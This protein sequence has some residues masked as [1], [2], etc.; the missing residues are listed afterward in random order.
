[1]VAA[2][3]D[4][5]TLVGW[6]ASVS[7]GVRHAFIIDLIVDPEWQ[8]QGLGTRLLANISQEFEKSGIGIIHADF[9][10]E[11]ASF[12]ESCGFQS[13]FAGIMHLAENQP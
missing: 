7:D 2:Y 4:K 5:E 11:N 13:S 8:R 10:S 3:Y 9:T 12:Y 1:M 6:C